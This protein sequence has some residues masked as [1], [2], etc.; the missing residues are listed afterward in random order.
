MK[1]F[2][3]EPS[4]FDAMLKLLVRCVIYI[5]TIAIFS[6]LLRK[7]VAAIYVFSPFVFRRE[8][9]NEQ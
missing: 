9:H 6:Y 1:M 4:D 3:V 2:Q 7:A 8:V 5:Q